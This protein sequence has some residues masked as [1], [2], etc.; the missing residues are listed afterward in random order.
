MS[1]LGLIILLFIIGLEIEIKKLLQSS[2]AILIIGVTQFVFYVALGLGFFSLPWFDD[3]GTYGDLGN[4]DTLVRCG[5]DKAR[6]VVSTIPDHILK[7][8]SNM[9]LLIYTK[10]VNPKAKVVVT[11]ESIPMAQKLYK[12]GAEYVLLPRLGAASKLSSLLEELV[13]QETSIP[14]WRNAAGLRH[15]AVRY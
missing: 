4:P 2:W 8:N 13:I 7:G 6:I 10:R 9:N 15:M 5:I 3:G 1:E 11:A 14:A 12:A